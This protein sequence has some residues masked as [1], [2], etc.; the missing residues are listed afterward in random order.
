[1]K[2]YSVYSVSVL[3]PCC[4]SLIADVIDPDQADD[5]MMVAAG[6]CDELDALKD[7]YAGLPQML[8]QVGGRARK[9]KA[10]LGVLIIS[11]TMRWMCFE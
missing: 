3:L 4:R 8:T 2:T 5:G 6:V 11:I 1:M 7:R 9:S 10:Q